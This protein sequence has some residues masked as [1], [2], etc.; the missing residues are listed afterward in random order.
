[1]S[2]ANVGVVQPLLLWLR[3]FPGAKEPTPVRTRMQA[4][5]LSY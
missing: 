3:L 1:M 2:W 4:G 5:R